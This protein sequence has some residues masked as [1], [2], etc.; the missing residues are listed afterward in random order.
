M[1]EHISIQMAASNFQTSCSML[2]T[3]ARWVV[4]ERNVCKCN[5]LGIFDVVKKIIRLKKKDFS[6][7]TTLWGWKWHVDHQTIQTLQNCFLN[8]ETLTDNCVLFI[9]RITWDSFE[10]NNFKYIW[11]ITHLSFVTRQPQRRWDR[12]MHISTNPQGV[13]SFIL[14]NREHVI[15]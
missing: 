11:S 10:Q 15:L 2:Q 8:L 5:P 4:C 6:Q 3:S 14:V 13:T 12:K 7:T 1:W 9:Q